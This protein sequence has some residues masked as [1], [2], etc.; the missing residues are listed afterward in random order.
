MLGA[1]AAIALAVGSISATAVL[2][3]DQRLAADES[4]EPVVEVQAIESVDMSEEGFGF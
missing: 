1:L 4:R 2:T 3:E